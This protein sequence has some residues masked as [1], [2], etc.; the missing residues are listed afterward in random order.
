[1]KRIDAASLSQYVNKKHESAYMQIFCLLFGSIT[2][3]AVKHQLFIEV[4]TRI[5]SDDTNFYVL[6]RTAAFTQHASCGPE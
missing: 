6:W 4:R 2:D 5:E 3:R 1:M